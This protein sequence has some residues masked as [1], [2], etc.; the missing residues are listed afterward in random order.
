MC[1]RRKN[2]QK[3]GERKPSRAETFVTGT[4]SGCYCLSNFFLKR[5]AKGSNSNTQQYYNV[6]KEAE[7]SEDEK[8]A[9]E[10]RIRKK[11]KDMDRLKGYNLYSL[12]YSV[13]LLDRRPERINAAVNMSSKA[14]KKIDLTASNKKRNN[15]IKTISENIVLVPMG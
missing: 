5:P 2:K 14:D 8:T 6:R 7:R 9:A 12:S 4:I 11:K 15:K 10:R 3:Y 13:E 1:W